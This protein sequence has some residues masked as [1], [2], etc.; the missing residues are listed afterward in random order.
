M[1]KTLDKIKLLLE[2]K[3]KIIV[4]LFFL[5]FLCIGLFIFRDYGISWDGPLQRDIG[6]V[7]VN[8][9]VNNDKSIH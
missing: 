3:Y 8:Y 2:T 1:Y 7:S 6:T 5:I 9:I 4:I